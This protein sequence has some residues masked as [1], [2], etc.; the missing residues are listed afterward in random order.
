MQRGKANEMLSTDIEGI[1]MI[2]TH[3]ANAE[4]P[5]MTAIAPNTTG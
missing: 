4:T 2:M 1:N 3:S 5:T